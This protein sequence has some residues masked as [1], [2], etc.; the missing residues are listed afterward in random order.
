MPRPTISRITLGSNSWPLKNSAT[1]DFFLTAALSDQ[2]QQDP[3]TGR[4]RKAQ[5]LRSTSCRD[6]TRRANMLFWWNFNMD[7]SIFRASRNSS[8]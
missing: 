1:L 2:R 6:L 3:S 8:F 5:G 7:A 4:S